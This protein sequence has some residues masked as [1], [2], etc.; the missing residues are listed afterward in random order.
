MK[1]YH[2]KIGAVIAIM[3]FTGLSLQAQST[4]KLATSPDVSIKVLGSSNVHD[5]TMA[6]PAMY[7]K[8]DFNLPAHRLQ[9]FSF[10]LAV[11]SLKSEHASM[12]SRTYKAVNA[13]KFPDINYKLASATITGDNNKYLIET[14]GSLTFAGVTK[15]ISME[16][17][18]VVNADKSI[19]CTGA[20][21]IQLTDYGVKPPTF[22]LGTMKVYNDL[23]IQFKLIY[24]N[25]DILNKA[26]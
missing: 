19:T 18:A 8:G 13:T 24:K 14:E 23:T 1:N 11:T 20:K 22:M 15:T 3:L 5:W 16:V 21:K 2:N 26:L 7:S 6:S 12:D 4:Y 25:Q 9:S 10:R 17:T